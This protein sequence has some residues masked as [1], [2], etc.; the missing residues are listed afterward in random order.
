MEKE[1]FGDNLKVEYNVTDIDYKLPA[2]T[3]QTLAD[4]AIRHGIAN[5]KGGGTLTLNAYETDRYHVIEVGDDGQGFRMEED[6]NRAHI[7]I[8]NV[9][10]R[11]EYMCG[12]SLQIES[13][14][15]KGTVV[16]VRI[17]KSKERRA[18]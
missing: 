5:R 3:V 2:Y 11:L 15:G 13:Q 7:G 17:P 14:K 18:D 10:E 4:N 9:K 8:N 12:G 6:R 1:R 16:I